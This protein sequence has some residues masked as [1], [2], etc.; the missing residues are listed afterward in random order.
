MF[1]IVFSFCSS[2]IILKQCCKGKLFL[3]LLTAVV[4][5]VVA[6]VMGELGHIPKIQKPGFEPDRKKDSWK[7]G[8]VTHDSDPSMQRYGWRIVRSLRSALAT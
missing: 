5:A 7:S 3:T 2:H 4:T 1:A 8:V 6:A